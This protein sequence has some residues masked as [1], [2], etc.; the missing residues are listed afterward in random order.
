[1]EKLTLSIRDREKVEWAKTFAKEHETSVSRLFEEYLGALMAFDQ[2]EVTLS[3][4]L[5]SL[6]QP[7][8][9]PSDAQI[10]SHL[11]RR[12]TRAAF[13]HGLLN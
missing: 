10:E 8:Q 7:D 2:R 9:R 4:S 1:M 6:R 13:R 3:E 5:Q 12:F 11:T